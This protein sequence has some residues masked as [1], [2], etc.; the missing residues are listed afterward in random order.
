MAQRTVF[1][2]CQ[3]IDPKITSDHI[4]NQ[5]AKHEA[6]S[7]K[8]VATADLIWKITLNPE[9]DIFLSP[10]GYHKIKYASLLG[11]TIPT[12]FF[13]V[14]IDEEHDL[15][16]SLLQILDKSPQAVY[17][18][19]DC[20]QNL[21]GI[22]NHRSSTIRERQ[23]T[24]SF[25]TGP[26]IA[27]VII[28]IVRAHPFGAKEPFHGDERVSA[29]AEYYQKATI[30]EKPTTIIVEDEW[31]LWDWAQR[32]AAEKTPFLIPF[33]MDGLKLFVKD[34]LS[35]KENNR[36]AQHHL[37]RRFPNWSSLVD[38][39]QKNQNFRNIYKM[40]DRGY[41][42]EHWQDLVARHERNRNK[43]CHLLIKA[44][45]SRNQEYDRLMISPELVQTIIQARQNKDKLAK[46][47]STLYV[48]ITRTKH[49][50]IAPI[51]LREWIE[52]ASSWKN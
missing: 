42:L 8:V 36:R 30:P 43:N 9:K 34:I 15:P 46:A 6:V 28:P 18:F 22:L 11:I 31:A 24:H 39:C 41:T 7:N 32:L 4:T 29:K 49:L 47:G 33:S 40:L 50:L 45:D 44:V 3:S 14:L 20:Y 13:H 2:F 16:A 19:G 1:K 26:N 51:S 17:T 37:L 35:L 25:R 12:E 10:R 48:A 52:D 23:L 38:F 27:D 5:D 21:R